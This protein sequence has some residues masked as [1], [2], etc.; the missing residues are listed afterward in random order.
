MCREEDVCET[1]YRNTTLESS[2]QLGSHLSYER[3]RENDSYKYGDGKVNAIC[4][5]FLHHFKDQDGKYLQNEITA[6][7]CRIPPDLEAALRVVS[8]HKSMIRFYA[9]AFETNL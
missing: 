7:T 5:A 1:L 8:S 2:E 3:P 6:Y 9:N 4:N